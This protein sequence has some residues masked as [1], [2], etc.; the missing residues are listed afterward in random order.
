V[1]FI[2]LAAVYVAPKQ[3]E[4]TVTFPWQP[5]Q[6]LTYWQW[7]MYVNKTKGTPSCVSMA[8]VVTR[9]RHNVSLLPTLLHYYSVPFN[10]NV[11][12]IPMSYTKFLPFS[13]FFPLKILD[14]TDRKAEGGGGGQKIG[15]F[16]SVSILMV[17]ALKDQLL[18]SDAHRFW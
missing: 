11:N 3:S 6:C 9:T 15:I 8:T 12:S 13:F 16:I 17:V 5:F 14:V 2:L 4:R 1:C 18:L 7:H 10:I